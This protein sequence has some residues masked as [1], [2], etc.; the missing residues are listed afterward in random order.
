MFVASP[1]CLMQ[2]IWCMPRSGVGAA[3]PQPRP[4]LCRVSHQV[5]MQAVHQQAQHLLAVVLAPVAHAPPQRRLGHP[6]PQRG[7][8]HRLTRAED[9]QSATDFLAKQELSAR[10][11]PAAKA[12]SPMSTH[13]AMYK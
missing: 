13:E 1:S 8:V 10:E 6:S 11:S 7:G 5:I 12:T 2:A 4:Q 3:G 9:L